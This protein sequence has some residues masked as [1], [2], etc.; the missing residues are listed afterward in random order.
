MIWGLIFTAVLLSW[1]VYDLALDELM[2]EYPSDPDWHNTATAIALVL[3]PWM[4]G[5]ALWFLLGVL[6]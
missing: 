6:A 4:C 3:F 5:A 1:W 2:M